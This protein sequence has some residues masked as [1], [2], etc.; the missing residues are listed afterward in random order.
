MKGRHLLPW[1]AA[2]LV[3]LALLGKQADA[4]TTLD[5]ATVFAIF[6]QANTTDIW[7]ARLG[8][9]YGRSDEVRSLARMVA[10]DHE[11]VQQ[12]G[13]DLARKLGII[14]TPP[15]GDASAAALAKAVGLL[16]SK[17]GADFD[18]AYL[19]YEIAF[20]RSVIA[21]LRGSLLPA[22]R[23]PEFKALV[24]KTMPGFEHH[25]AATRAVADK[26]GVH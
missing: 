16:Q 7:T 17:S 1:T 25:L 26:L 14:P 12:M 6:D 13:R 9:K 21:A 20:H 19:R 2:L 5:D 8:V 3:V 10:A 18:R 24:E 4:A 11:A 22:I 23:N 15:S